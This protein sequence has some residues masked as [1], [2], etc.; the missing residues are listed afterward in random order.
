MTMLLCT[1]QS[2]SHDVKLIERLCDELERWLCTKPPHPV[3][4]PNLSNALV[5]E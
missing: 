2:P 5:G 1:K 4:Q 3:S